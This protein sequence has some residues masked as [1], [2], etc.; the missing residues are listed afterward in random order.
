MMVIVI[1]CNRIRL[2]PVDDVVV[3]YSI[4]LALIDQAF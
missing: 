4:L 3:L 2:R 1:K